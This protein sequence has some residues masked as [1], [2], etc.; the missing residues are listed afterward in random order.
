MASC[1]ERPWSFL[2]GGLTFFMSNGILPATMHCLPYCAV[3]CLCMWSHLVS[4]WQHPLCLHPL[5]LHP[6][7]FPSSEDPH[8]CRQVGIPIG[9]DGHEPRQEDLQAGETEQGQLQPLDVDLGGRQGRERQVRPRWVSAPIAW[10]RAGVRPASKDSGASA[11]RCAPEAGRGSVGLGWG[12]SQSL[13]YAQRLAPT[14]P[15]RVVFED[16]RIS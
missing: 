5:W 1:P 4:A 7:C 10:A 14:G 16:W 9:H 13:L 6:L 3:G 2:L 8:L 15:R 11:P 12:L